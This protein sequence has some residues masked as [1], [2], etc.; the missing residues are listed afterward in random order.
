MEH[1]ED[2][3]YYSGRHY[4]NAFHIGFSENAASGKPGTWQPDPA[5]VRKLTRYAKYRLNMVRSAMGEAQ[6]VTLDGE[7]YALGFAEIRVIARDDTV[8]AAPDRIIAWV[9]NGSY[10]PPEVFVEAVMEGVDPDSAA[11]QQ[12]LEKYRSSFFWGA[13]EGCFR[14]AK[15][16]SE[17]MEAGD[18]ETLKAFLAE[19]PGRINMATPNGTLLNGALLLRN[20]EMAGY[21]LAAGAS[22]TLLNGIELLTAIDKG[23]IGTVQKLLDRDIPIRTDIVRNNPLFWA[24]AKKQNEAAELLYRVRRDLVRTYNINEIKNCNILQWAKICENTAFLQYM[25]NPR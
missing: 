5:F 25:I 22:V 21:L 10:M 12:Y 19:N 16:V 24:I 9:G 13:S 11:Y 6:S 14:E 4:E 1:F 8:Y 18:L 15:R 23:C 20:E 17:Y 2:F 7:T 3:T